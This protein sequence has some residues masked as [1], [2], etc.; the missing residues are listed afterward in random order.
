[1]AEKKKILIRIGSLRHGG[2][3]K[4]LV[5]LLK[6]LPQ[7][8]YEIDLLLNLYSG[9][10][11]ADV[12]EWINVLYLNKGEMITT[13]G[14]H[15][16]PKKAARVLYQ[17]ILK[18]FPSLLYKGKLKNKKYDIEFA[19]IH[20]MR[21]EILRSPLK[22]SKKIVWIHN[23]LSQVKG[24]TETEIRKFFG[25]DQIMVISEKIEQHFHSL[26]QNDAEHQKIIKI[27]NPLDTGEFITKAEEPVLNYTFDR[28]VPTFISVG[29]V[30]P[31]KGF[32]RLLKVHKR[33][34]DEGFRHKILIVGDGYDFENIRSQR[35]DLGLDE[36]VTM[37]GFT[38]NPYPYFKHADFYLLSSRYEGFPTVL[39]EAITLKKKI[40]ATEV[41]GA[42]EMLMNG[43]L[44]LLVENSDEG[45]Y[46]GMK[47]ALS[48]PEFFEQYL[49]R[50]YHYEMPF[51]LENSVSRIIS[52][53]DAP[54]K[55][56][57]NT[58]Q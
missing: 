24:Y 23:D 45:I 40:I 48:Q 29:T 44:G 38:D 20:G 34:L 11:L 15:E 51:T 39:F 31:Q 7:D 28:S 12:P 8:Q 42:G 16:I 2:A 46:T 52:V 56:S 41:S 6:N 14:P 3:E 5:T 13:N 27:Y 22:A 33:L 25:F 37:L 43:A 19:A 10:Y 17:G 35:T 21:D 54:C 36:T 58:D 53:L 1:M 30:F 50:L 55:P 18:R 49:E 57:F 47:K 32:D 9:K 26:A 4:V